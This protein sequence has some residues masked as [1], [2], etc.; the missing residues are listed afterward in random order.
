MR[1][2]EAAIKKQRELLEAYFTYLQ[3]QL[4]NTNRADVSHMA[5]CNEITS[6]EFYFKV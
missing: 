4:Q 5:Q 1:E 3:M 6:R 2:R